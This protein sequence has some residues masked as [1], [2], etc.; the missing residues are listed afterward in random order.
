[1]KSSVSYR[2]RENNHKDAE[3]HAVS[4]PQR[5]VCGFV[6]HDRYVRLTNIAEDPNSFRADP[7]EVAQ[8]LARYGEPSA[9]FHSHPNGCSEPSLSD[10]RL[11]SYYKNSTIIIGII[12]NGGLELCQVVAPP[13]L[14]PAPAVQP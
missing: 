13:Q 6:Y 9:I 12:N 10:L 1:M 3:Q 8:C 2:M 14:D 11:A 5:E 4:S 7:A